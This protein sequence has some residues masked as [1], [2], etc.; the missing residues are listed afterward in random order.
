[1]QIPGPAFSSLMS[2]FAQ[3]MGRSLDIDSEGFEFETEG[4]AVRLLPHPLNPDL[5]LLEAD[6][7]RLG[8]AE[9]GDARLL[10]MLHQLN[11]TSSWVTGW[12][13]MVD[14][15]GHLVLR[16]SLGLK[17]MTAHDLQ[18]DLLEALDRTQALQGLVAEIL[19]PGQAG[20][21]AAVFDP[22][23]QRV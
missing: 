19:T 10:L 12:V 21:D 14:L 8:K 2:E 5:G 17:E 16:R 20:I 7:C 18:G 11:E 4:V 1:M 3:Q 9:Q 6:V 15:E 13:A 23:V 22:G